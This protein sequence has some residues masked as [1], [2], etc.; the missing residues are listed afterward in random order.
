LPFVEAEQPSA[1]GSSSGQGP[2]RFANSENEVAVTGAKVFRR[3]REEHHRTFRWG[4]GNKFRMISKNRFM[5]VHKE[6]PKEVM[7]RDDFY[8]SENPNI[9]WEEVNECWEVFW[10]EHH[11]LNA[12]PFHTK[13]YGVERAKKEAFAFFD[14]L[15]EAGRLRD[16]PKIESPQDG[17][18]FD[19]RMQGWVCFFWRNGRPH[20]RTFSARK[21]GFDGAQKLAQAKQDDPVNGLY[22]TAPGGGTPLHLKRLGRGL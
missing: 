12:K 6:R 8:E 17:V 5:P 15:G 3:E 9:V 4:V 7:V 16:P 19:H 20:A 22:H 10:Y 18:F 1:S 2:D 11:K 21:W 13:K 14:E